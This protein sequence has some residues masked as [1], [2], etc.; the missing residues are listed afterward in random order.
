M[1]RGVT[2]VEMVVVL[3]IVGIAAAAVAPAIRLSAPARDSLME[4][5]DVLTTLLT[6][7]RRRAIASAARVTLTID[8]STGR[9]WICCHPERSEGS[10]LGSDDEKQIPRFARDDRGTPDDRGARDDTSGVLQLPGGITLASDNNRIHF[11]FNPN[12]TSAG[13]SIAIRA[14]SRV[15]P[16]AIDP[17]TGALIEKP[18]VTDHALDGRSADAR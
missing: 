18:I 7:A 16:L 12:G 9:Y 11:V 10:A 4:G 17:W 1:K 3:A 8:P 6:D 2:L 13:E 15:E 5:R 14:G